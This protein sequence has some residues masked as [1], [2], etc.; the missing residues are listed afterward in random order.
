MDSEQ[1]ASL[2]QQLKQEQT[3]Q[4][5][6]DDNPEYDDNEADYDENTAD[7]NNMDSSNTATTNNNSSSNNNNNNN[8]ATNNNETRFSP[9]TKRKKQDL[10][11]SQKR[12][13]NQTTS[14][15]FS[16]LAGLT[17]KQAAHLHQQQQQQQQQQKPNLSQMS[18]QPA[19]ATRSAKPAHVSNTLSLTPQCPRN[20]NTSTSSSASNTS[21][22]NLI[23]N[24]PMNSS[25]LT[26]LNEKISGNV[27]NSLQLQLKKNL[28]LNN[29]TKNQ[30]SNVRT[31]VRSTNGP[32]YYQ[33]N[34][35]NG[36]IANFNASAL[37][38]NLGLSN[39]DARLG[40][41]NS[42]SLNSFIESIAKKTGS[43]I[44]PLGINEAKKII[45]KFTTWLMLTSQT[46]ADHYV[47]QYAGDVLQPKPEISA[48]D[49]I[50]AYKMMQKSQPQ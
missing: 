46:I 39:Y 5:N 16:I 3:D 41:D 26:L 7:N 15:L 2:P 13:F 17:K 32:S 50:L 43:N 21:T 45:E 47:A 19:Q 23:N 36:D 42:L 27:A 12:V 31:N 6:E 28:E 8:T 24:L 30:N 38:N 29:Q 40:T 48:S 35:P 37:M 10:N 33:Q 11:E 49:V 34:L 1:E 22:N 18:Q 25:L 14:S 9:Q 20:G 44:G 4:T